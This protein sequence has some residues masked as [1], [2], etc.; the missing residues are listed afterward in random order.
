MT[1]PNAYIDGQL[2]VFDVL[3]LIDQAAKDA[4]SGADDPAA[5]EWTTMDEDEY[6]ATCPGYCLSEDDEIIDPDDESWRDEPQ[7]WEV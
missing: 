2:D 7:D 1:D 6:L 5:G 3:A 4:V